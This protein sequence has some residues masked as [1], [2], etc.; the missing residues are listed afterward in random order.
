TNRLLL[1]NSSREIFLSDFAFTSHNAIS[2]RNFAIKEMMSRGKPMFLIAYIYSVTN[3]PTVSASF[4]TLR[5]IL[6]ILVIR[7]GWKTMF[8][9]TSV[10]SMSRSTTEIAI[11]TN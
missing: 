4:P 9:I 7:V 8:T 10:F 6:V 5:H 3:L 1:N 11:S 2:S